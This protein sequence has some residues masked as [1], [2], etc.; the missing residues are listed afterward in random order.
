ME[1]QFKKLYIDGDYANCPLCKEEHKYL[2][3][4]SYKDL[5]IIVETGSGIPESGNQ[6]SN[7]VVSKFQQ[8]SESDSD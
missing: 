8:D 6:G 7:R 2:R 4:P 3:C 1:D 5:F